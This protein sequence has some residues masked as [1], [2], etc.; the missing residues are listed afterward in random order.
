MPSAANKI[1]HIITRL[2]MGGS[3]QNT[4]LTCLELSGTYEMVLA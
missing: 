3:V 4:L 2:D 1:L